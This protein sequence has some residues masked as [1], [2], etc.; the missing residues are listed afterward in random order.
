MRIFKHISTL[1]LALIVVGCG[2][3]S[4]EKEGE[5]NIAEEIV[6]PTYLYGINIDGYD[7]ANDTVRMGE[8]VCW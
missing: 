6:E 8:T 1:L 7:V 5:N 3:S 4:T 2:G